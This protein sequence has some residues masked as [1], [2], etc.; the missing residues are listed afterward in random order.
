MMNAAGINF[1]RQARLSEPAN[2]QKETMT[3][4]TTSDGGEDQGINGTEINKGRLKV[5]L[6]HTARAA[7]T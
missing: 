7:Y 4:C 1:Q 3:Q 6:S 5:S 2:S